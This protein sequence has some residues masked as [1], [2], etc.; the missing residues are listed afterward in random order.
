MRP[1][2]PR[3]LSE[4]EDVDSHV[5]EIRSACIFF[6]RCAPETVITLA[7]MSLGLLHDVLGQERALSRR[8]AVP[9]PK[10]DE[11]T[12]IRDED[13]ERVVYTD[14]PPVKRSKRE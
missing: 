10:V 13:E 9:K 11:V 4:S 12:E 5:C 14:P 2:H 8:H 7:K 3:T 1:V 6:S